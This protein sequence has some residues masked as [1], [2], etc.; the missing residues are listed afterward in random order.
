MIIAKV[1]SVAKITF[2]G[3]SVLLSRRVGFD[4]QSGFGNPERVK[5]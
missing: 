1:V 3:C 4:I 5:E 2:P